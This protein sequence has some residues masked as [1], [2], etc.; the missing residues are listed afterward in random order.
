MRKTREILRLRLGEDR[1][2]REVTFACGVSQSTVNDYILRAYLAGLSWPLPAEMDDAT[3]EA[4][5]FPTE[6][7]G[8]NERAP[9]DLEYIYKEMPRKGVTLIALPHRRGSDRNY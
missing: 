8:T 9:I 5:M 6:K 3:L 1:K 2:Q 4:K 7:A